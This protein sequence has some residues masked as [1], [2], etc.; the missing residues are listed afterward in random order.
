MSTPEQQPNTMNLQSLETELSLSKA[1]MEEF[2]KLPKEEQERQKNEKLSKLK[3]LQAKLDEAIQEAIQTGQIEEA[4]RLQEILG[5][6]TADLEEQIY[7]TEGLFDPERDITAEDF[8]SIIDMIKKA[9]GNRWDVFCSYSADVKLLFPEKASE[10]GLDKDTWLGIEDYVQK[11][12]D[13]ARSMGNNYWGSYMV[14]LKDAK[15]LFPERANELCSDGRVWQ[16][17]KDYIEKCKDESWANFS[18]AA[19][20][21]MIIHNF[22]FGLN[23]D[24]VTWGKIKKYIQEL[25]NKDSALFDEVKSRW[26][27]A[28]F[29][30]LFPKK[31]SEFVLNKQDWLEM[32]ND[33]KT[34]RK[35][36]DWSKFIWQAVMMKILAAEEVKVTDKGLEIVMK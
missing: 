33:L 19:M 35:N 4:K 25:K 36:H 27:I 8:V 16:G 31:A 2:R 30:I 20:N 23:L 18:A 5:K 24:D 34:A 3:D 13:S 14:A 11:S 12:K 7:I 26:E 6:G 28:K 22:D 32:N 9:R 29:K 15:I 1:E 10:L 21:A 17:M